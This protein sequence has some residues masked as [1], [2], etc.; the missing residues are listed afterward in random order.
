LTPGQRRAYLEW[1]ATGRRDPD[2][3]Q[4]ALGYV[5]MAFYGFERRILID[6][7]TDPALLDEVMQLMQH[8]GLTDATC[9]LRSYFLQ[10]L[11]VGGWRLGAAFYRSIW[12]DLLQIDGDRPDSDGMSM[13]LANLY[14]LGEPL[15]WTVAYRVALIDENSR[16]STVTNRV[17]EQFWE[18]F[19]QRFEES[20]PGGIIL[21]AAKQDAVLTCQPANRAL[22]QLAIQ[23]GT[24]RLEWRFPNVLGMR[25]QFKKL[26]EIWNS[27]VQDLSGYSR[28]RGSK[29]QGITAAIAAWKALPGALQDL[30]EHPVR[31]AMNELLA[32]SPT[33]NGF[34]VV[35]V[36]DIA[37][38]HDIPMREK[39]TV[40]QFSKLSESLAAVGWFITPNP[41]FV[42]V[43]LPWDQEVAIY[44]RG[45]WEVHEP[46]I[47]A[48]IRLLFLATALAA[49]DG[50]VT[51]R[52]VELFESHV[53][54]ELR[55]ERDWKHLRATQ[56]VLRRDYN[57][58]VRSLPQIARSIPLRSRNHVFRGLVHIAASDGEVGPDEIK[59]LRRIEKLLTLPETTLDEFLGK[60]EAFSEV[61]V[62]N[63]PAGVPDSGGP[64]PPQQ[65]VS[66]GPVSGLKLDRDRL[67]ALKKETHEVITMLAEVMSEEESST[68][69][70]DQKSA[71]PPSA[72]S[73]PVPPVDEPWMLALD[74]RYRGALWE[75][76]RQEEVPC[77][78]FDRIA[79]KHLLMPDD[80][81]SSVNSWS[82]ECL[83][84]FLLERMDVVRVYL[85]LLPPHL[86][87]S[88]SIP[89]Q[90]AA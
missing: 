54:S 55:S 83:G 23:G 17:P 85:D 16:R 89:L 73:V 47:P 39:L 12:P 51:D 49:A 10:L 15:H 63:P 14:E 8:Y 26:P 1:L 36:G 82:D 43:A 84:D 64:I 32:E 44:P 74:R 86:R 37:T 24:S 7:D 28:A 87:V 13:V 11:H 29:K 67:E 70:V 72:A 68:V 34:P 60:D 80:L 4:R 9:H 33:E 38:I 90:A 42:S 69:M 3:A 19:H 65:S 59:V 35:P 62:V 76:V 50:V 57:L 52:E 81:L 48:V 21:Q 56:A 41:A 30:D 45:H 58:A 25:R 22:L 18:L 88:R 46:Q 40:G 31:M 53:G 20:H 27:C 2:P 61:V 6:G 5:L 66:N 78:V 79:G 71:L 77:D 75:L